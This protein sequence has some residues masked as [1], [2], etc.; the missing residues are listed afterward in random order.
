MRKILL[1]IP[2]LALTL[3]SAAQA[4]SG[5]TGQSAPGFV[6]GNSTASQGLPSFK[7]QTSL[8]DRAFSSTQ[9][10][11]LNRGASNWSA[12]ATPSLGL[13]GTTSGSI[14]F[15]GASSGNITLGVAAAAGSSLLFQLPNTN[16]VLNNV[17]QTDG[18]GH[19][20]WTSVGSGTV[21]SVGLALPASTFSI[22]NSP[23]TT[24]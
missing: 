19:L 8:L 11:I 14:T 12:T 1:L 22:S 9:G 6:C 24:T 21:S 2:F 18:A 16:G 15:N 4:Q 7:S 3:P 10:V 5:C 17:L 13:N 20:S 23:V